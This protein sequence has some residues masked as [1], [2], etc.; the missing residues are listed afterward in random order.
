MEE[1][2]RL[3]RACS[4]SM[5]SSFFGDL[6]PF[7]SCHLR[8]PRLP[9]LARQGDRLRVAGIIYY[10]PG[11]VPGGTTFGHSPFAESRTALAIWVRSSRLLARVG[12]NPT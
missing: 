3:V 5:T 11:G 6:W 7:L 9:A 1:L 2:S 12:I 4:P 10:S 8:C